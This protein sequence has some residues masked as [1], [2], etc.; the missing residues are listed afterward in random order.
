MASTGTGNHGNKVAPGD[1]RLNIDGLMPDTKYA[2]QVRAVDNGVDSKWSQKYHI[3]T[4]DDTAGGSRTPPVPELTSFDCNSGQFVAVW[5]T[6]NTYDDGVSVMVVNSYE[7]E[8]SGAFGTIISPHYGTATDTQSRQWTLPVLKALFGGNLPTVLTA[9]LR[10]LSSARTPSEWSSPLTASLPVPNPPTNPKAEG[11]VDGVKVTWEPPTDPIHLFGY[12]VYVAIGDENAGFFPSPMNLVYQGGALETTYT[13]LS[14]DFTHYFKIVSYSEAGLESTWVEANAKPVSPYGPDLI[15]PEKPVLGDPTMD[16][17]VVTNPKAILA[18]EHDAEHVNNKDTTG[19]VIRWKIV[20]ETRWRNSYFD[21]AARTGVIDLP[22]PF[23]NYE[24]EIAAYDFVANY[25]E[26][27]GT[28]KTLVGANANPPGPVQ[29][30]DAVARWDGLRIFWETSDESVKYGGLYH[31]Q[32]NTTGEWAEEA[33]FDYS[34]AATSI[35]ITGLQPLTAYFYRVRAVDSS[36]RPGA[37]SDIKTKTLPAFPTGNTL[38]GEAPSAAPANVRATG[39]LNYINLAWDRVANDDPVWYEVFISD[40]TIPEITESNYAEYFVGESTGTSL[41]IAS[42][43]NGEMLVQDTTYYLRVRARDGDNPG[44]VSAEV[45]SKLTQVL[46]TDLGINMAGENLLYNSSFDTDSDGNGVADYF[47]IVNTTAVTE[48]HTATLVSGRDGFGKAQRVSW[49]GVNTGVKGVRSNDAPVLRPDTEYLVSFYARASAVGGFGV[50]ADPTLASVTPDPEN[51]ETTNYEYRRFFFRVKTRSIGNLDPKNVTVYSN[52]PANNG[53]FD[54]DD[55]QIEAGNTASAYKTGTVSVAKLTS[56]RMSTAEM[57]IDS[58]GIVKSSDYDPAQRRGWAIHAGGID[59]YRGQIDASIL[60][61]DSVIGNNLYVANLIEISAGGFIRSSNYHNG[62]PVNGVPKAAAGFSINSAGIDIRSGVV[63]AGTLTSGVI[64]APDIRLNGTQAIPGKLTI[65]QWGSIQS[66]NY[67]F[68]PAVGSIPASGTGWKISSTGIEMWDVNSKINVNA[69]ETSTLTSTV[70]TMGAGGVIQSATWAAGTGP[71]WALQ[72]GPDGGF[73]MYNGAITGAIIR[74]GALTST[75]LVPGPGGVNRPA[76]DMN[77]GG[78]TAITG[79]RVYGNSVMGNDNANVL[80]SGNFNAASTGWKIWGS[81]LAE[82]NQV[83]TRGLRVEGDAIVSSTSANQL[84]SES[85]SY[86]S[87]GNGGTGWLLRGDGYGEFNGGMMRIGNPGGGSVMMT[88][89]ANGTNAMLRFY[90]PGNTTQFGNIRQRVDNVLEMRGGWGGA[91][92]FNPAWYTGRTLVQIAQDLDVTGLARVNNGLV[93]EGGG[94]N[95]QSGGI[96]LNGGVNIRNGG[97]D[98][99]GADFISRANHNTFGNNIW[100]GGLSAPNGGGKREVLISDNNL[101]IGG[102]QR[103]SS[104]KIKENVRDFEYTKEQVLSLRPVRY[105]LKDK[106][107]YDTSTGE[108]SFS[109]VI[110][111]EAARA[112]LDDFVIT[113]ENNEIEDF[114]YQRFTSALLHVAREQQKEIDELKRAVEKLTKRS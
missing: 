32:Y 15:P 104:I 112:G 110:A 102:N 40:A 93:I 84:R 76:F 113:D 106:F 13:S 108:N 64:T 98:V 92:T 53:W 49:T 48:P 19:F 87:G 29:G 16:R 109:G 44:P 96:G 37:W 5:N 58:L 11:V 70:I 71:R 28:T 56:G 69:L 54:I 103:G 89:D 34:T 31:V 50:T 14:Y 62:T 77:E 47:E 68:T 74:T 1:K 24:F 67:A 51:P 3:E 111:E 41:M 91:I 114:D 83:N 43:A 101:Y 73:T 42:K 60:A 21:K 20:G 86:N 97:L 81:G 95:V 66:N 7:I 63:A 107:W 18:W 78:Y 100:H 94:I 65:D 27:T 45:N 6:V 30:V 79:L 82:F 25:S 23:A 46:S 17:S 39:G 22:N 10:V 9:R 61:A 72:D 75:N 35:D 4:I 36:D 105:K 80:Q 33:T 88:L 55:M 99:S 38:D 59:A 57:I 85:F 90:Q 52:N 8:L 2:V 12:R 26:Y